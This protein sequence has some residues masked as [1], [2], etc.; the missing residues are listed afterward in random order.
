MLLTWK[1]RL[2]MSYLALIAAAFVVGRVRAVV[3]RAL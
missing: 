3:G 2:T 1:D